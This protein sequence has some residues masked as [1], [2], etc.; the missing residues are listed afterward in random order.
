VSGVDGDSK[1]R[2]SMLDTRCQAVR[3]AIR[4]AVKGARAA[5]LRTG[6]RQKVPSDHSTVSATVAALRIDSVSLK[7]DPPIDRLAHI[8]AAEE[9]VLSP[10]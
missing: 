10:R 7:P 1:V 4:P 9:G 6:I 8:A 2:P 5:G 3:L